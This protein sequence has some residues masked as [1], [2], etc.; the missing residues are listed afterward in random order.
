MVPCCEEYLVTIDEGEGVLEIINN[1][2]ILLERYKTPIS[3][4]L[5]GIDD[6]VVLLTVMIRE[7]LMKKVLLDIKENINDMK[8][9][10]DQVEYRMG[11]GK[12]VVTYI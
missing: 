5:D 9:L 7:V 11:K 8:I 4:D 12:M 6:P 2:N 10:V 3:I 1:H